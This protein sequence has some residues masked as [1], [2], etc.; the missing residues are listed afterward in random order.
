MQGRQRGAEVRVSF[1][2]ADHEPAR[3]GDGEVHAGQPGLRR[4][5]LLAQVPARRL[6]ELGRVGQPGRRAQLV[7]E[8]IADLLLLLVDGGHHDVAGRLLGELDDALSQVRIDHLD[9]AFDQIWIEVAL[10]GEHRLAL[11]QPRHAAVA[12][13]AVHDAVVLVRVA[14]P[15][16]LG[17]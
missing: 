6:G 5:E 9:A 13:D 4:Q 7:V 1:V 17:T 8:E 14:S 12:Q 10:F 15:V 3:L 16:H 2:G 11:H